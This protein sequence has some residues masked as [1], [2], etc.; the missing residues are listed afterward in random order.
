MAVK[1]FITLAPRLIFAS[2]DNTCGLY[3]KH[4]YAPRG[5]IYDR[6]RHASNCS[7]TLGSQFTLVAKAN[8]AKI[9]VLQY[10]PLHYDCELHS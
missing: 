5:M 7:I 3:Y 8:L 1:S 10:T 4:Y 2:K 6:K 9:V